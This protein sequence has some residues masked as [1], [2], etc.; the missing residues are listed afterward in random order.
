MPLLKIQKAARIALKDYMGLEESE[1]LLVIADPKMR[2]IALAIYEA[3]IIIAKEAFYIEMRE[4]EVNGEEP[5]EQIADLM[6][7]VDVVVAVTSKSLTHT[8]ARREASK[9]GVRVGTMPGITEETMIRCLNGNIDKVLEITKKVHNAFQN[10]SKVKVLAKHGTNVTF[11]T[12][13]RKS[14]AS[15]GILR[16]IGE[17]GNLPSG[18]VYIAPVENSVNGIIAFDAS[19]A[20]LGVLTHPV[21]IEVKNGV[22]KKISGRGGDA[23][24]FGKLVNRY[25]EKSKT[26]GE[27]GIGTNPYAKV[28]GEILED[29]KVLGT[30][31]FAFGNNIS[32]GGTIDVAFHIDGIISKPTVYF[33]DKI[34][35]EDGKLLLE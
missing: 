30:V 11:D 27:F 24:L 14:V 25:G 34:I 9:N 3:G 2:E 1:N 35:M 23:R 12:T 19:I 22:I 8:N 33:D 17:S 32:F 6:K 4:R 15:T 5:P 16:N 18:E 7:A 13:N 31:H 26:V 28:C 10:V 20:N 29:E 21:Y